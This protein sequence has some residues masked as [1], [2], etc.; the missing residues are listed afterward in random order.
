MTGFEKQAL[1]ETEV[2]AYRNRARKRGKEKEREE[3]RAGTKNNTSPLGT[4]CQESYS[5]AALT[6]SSLRHLQSLSQLQREKKETLPAAG[7]V[8]VSGKEYGVRNISGPFLETQSSMPHCFVFPRH[9]SGGPVSGVI[10]YLLSK[11][12]TIS[13]TSYAL[14]IIK[15]RR[16]RVHLR[17]SAPK[18]RP[19]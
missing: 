16:L 1:R 14:P 15:N 18:T 13:S 19:S 9:Q 8:K 4:Q 17:K 3:E 5:I 6:F 10:S 7:G 2:D 12:I 11:Y